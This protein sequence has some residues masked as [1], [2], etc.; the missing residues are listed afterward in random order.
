MEIDHSSHTGQGISETVHLFPQ[1][2]NRNMHPLD[3]IN[4]K[5]GQFTM[6]AIVSELQ[7]RLP[8]FRARK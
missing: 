1:K 6:W 4:H 5:W 3:N 7:P 8:H 2:K